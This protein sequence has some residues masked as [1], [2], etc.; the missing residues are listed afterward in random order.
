[1]RRGAPHREPGARVREAARRRDQGP[2]GLR[3]HGHEA[4]QGVREH[5]LVGAEPRRLSRREGRRGRRGGRGTVRGGPAGVHGQPS[6]GGAGQG[7]GGRR[8]RAPDERRARQPGPQG[9]ALVQVE[10]GQEVDG[11]EPGDDGDVQPARDGPHGGGGRGGDRRRG[12][13]RHRSGEEGPAGRVVHPRRRGLRAR[14]SRRRVDPARHHSVSHRQE[15]T[16]GRPSRPGHGR[17]ALGPDAAVRGR[18]RLRG[19]EGR[20]PARGGGRGDLPLQER[21]RGRR[22]GGRVQRPEQGVPRPPEAEGG[23]PPR[24]R[25]G[26]ALEARGRGG[27]GGGEEAVPQ[28]EPEPEEEGRA[29]PPRADDGGG[30]DGGGEDQEDQQEDQLRRHVEFV[31]RRRAVLDGP[32]E[33]RHEE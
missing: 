9:E 5:A 4:G 23:R 20:R 12:R 24:G 10:E 25:G 21:R 33:R 28:D 16:A 32:A 17:G 7:R 19:V 22:A 8:R 6:T 2:E 13:R 15:P 3:R 18:P 31:R 30:A 11:P 27:P 1:M 26:G 14:P 29:R